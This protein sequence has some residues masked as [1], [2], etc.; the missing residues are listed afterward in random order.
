MIKMSIEKKAW[1]YLAG[2]LS[3]LILF[4]PGLLAQ[5]GDARVE[6][7]A[8]GSFLKADRTFIID[9]TPKETDYA[10]GGIFGGRFTV[11]LSKNFAVEAAYGGGTNNLRVFDRVTPLIE[12]GFGVRVHRFTGNALYYI[13]GN[14]APSRF[15]VTAGAGLVRFG[16]TSDAKSAAAIAFIDEPAA[17]DANTKVDFNFGGGFESKL[18][19]VFGVRLD[20]RDHMA[21]IPR[22]GVPEAPAPGILDF[23]PVS[24]LAHNWETSIGIVFHLGHR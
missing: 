23:F 1:M 17:I 12:R 2:L 4:P 22:Y 11:D 14:E 10:K 7:F 18:T 16:P 9:G 6:I 8:G 3:L 19:D 15:F 13:G 21:P 24:G 5:N 20:V